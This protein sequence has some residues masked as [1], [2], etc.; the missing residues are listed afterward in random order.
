M[1]LKFFHHYIPEDTTV[2]VD[3]QGHQVPGRI[4]QRAGTPR[5]YIVKY[6]LENYEE[7]EHTS[8]FAWIIMELHK[9]PAQTNIIQQHPLLHGQSLALRQELSFTLLII[10]NMGPRPRK[11]R[12]DISVSNR[13]YI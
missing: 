7:I 13:L 3:N 11:G 12:C 2:W 1:E 10:Y 6:P 8:G 4:L 5:S 9:T